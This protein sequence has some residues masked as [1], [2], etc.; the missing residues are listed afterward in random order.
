MSDHAIPGVS[1]ETVAEEPPRPGP[2]RMVLNMGPQH[3]STHGVLRLLLELDGETVVECRPEIGYLHT[4]IEKEFEVKTYQQAVTL[5]DRVD[6]LAP[7]SNN[8]CYSLAVE[9]LLGLEIPPQAQWMRVMLTE[10]T[11]LNSHLVWLGTH[12]ID[13]GAMSVFLYCFREREEIL[14]IFEMFSGQRMMNSYFRVGGLAL[15]A[16]RGWQHVVKKFVDMFPSKIDEYE[17]LL[18]NNP[19]W[20]RRTKNVGHLPIEDMLD[21][22]IT[23]PMLRGAGLRW[24]IRKDQPYSSYE[25]FDFQVPVQT[26][27]DVFARY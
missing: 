5:T 17:N 13:I 18:T 20:T 2:R 27:N 4:G 21:L 22:G 3:P 24:D 19:I 23:G 9:K 11:R 6:Y 1:V 15:D 8:L 25:K 10:L 26:A 12:A 16:P 14:R 7:L